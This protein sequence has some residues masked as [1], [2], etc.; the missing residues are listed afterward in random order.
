MLLDHFNSF[1]DYQPVDMLL[2]F[3]LF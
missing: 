2:D 3:S 1:T